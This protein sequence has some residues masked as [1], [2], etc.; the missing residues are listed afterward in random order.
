MSIIYVHECRDCGHIWELTYSLVD[1]TPSICPVCL[2][3][4]VFRHVTISG[5]VK[6]KGAG[7]S[8]TGYSKFTAYEK[9]KA[10]GQSVTLYDSKEEHDRVSKGEAEVFEK[11]RLKKLD[12]ISKRTLGVDA[13]VTQKEAD[14]KIKK[15]GKDAV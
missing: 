10:K 3:N 13:G 6:F 12:R 14:V 15:A 7:W 9:L 4:D 8:P 11:K 1:E 2:E 5:A